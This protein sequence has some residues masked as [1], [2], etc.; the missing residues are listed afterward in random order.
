MPDLA[1]LVLLAPVRLAQAQLAQAQLAL[2]QLALALVLPGPELVL[3]ELPVVPVLALMPAP[4]LVSVLVLG[5]LLDPF[6]FP[7]LK[8][9]NY[10]AYT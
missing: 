5:Y 1:L 3:P 8:L 7:S 4:D 2:A 10:F 9:I 6:Y